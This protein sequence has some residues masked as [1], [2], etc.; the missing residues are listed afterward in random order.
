[1]IHFAVHLSQLYYNKILRETETE[2][3]FNLSRSR[4][5]KGEIQD[6][7]LQITCLLPCEQFPSISLSRAGFHA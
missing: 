4:Q 5:G 7:G 2:R 1:M 3:R 6:T